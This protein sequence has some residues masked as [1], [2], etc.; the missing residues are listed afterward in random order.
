MLKVLFI[1]DE[2]EAIEPVWSLIR[3]EEEDMQYEISGFENAEDKIASFRPDIVILDLLVGG[4]SPEPKPEG[5]KTYDFIWDQHFCPIVVYSA[6]PGIH[7]D[8]HGAAPIREE[9]S[10]GD[11]EAPGRY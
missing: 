9:Y 4:A 2:P 8:R 1:E 6:E 5:L 3:K 11:E 10:E 7:E